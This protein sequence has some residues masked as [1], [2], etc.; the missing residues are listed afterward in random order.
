MEL[1]IP[2]SYGPS[3]L[4]RM[5]AEGWFA[6]PWLASCRDEFAAAAAWKTAFRDGGV[7]L[8]DASGSAVPV[9]DR[10]A[11]VLERRTHDANQG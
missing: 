10:I 8:V 2:D 6:L 3:G 5:L 7:T 4:Y 9:S 1:S 11:A